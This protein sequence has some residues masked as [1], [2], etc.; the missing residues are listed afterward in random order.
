MPWDFDITLSRKRLFHHARR[1]PVCEDLA[2]GRA[3]VASEG[4][5]TVTGVS[6]YLVGPG[7]D[8]GES[9]PVTVPVHHVRTPLAGRVACDDRHVHGR[10]IWPERETV[11]RHVSR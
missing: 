8:D 3:H 10:R 4:G 6:P 5:V 1:L 2:L 9:G 7:L 11:D